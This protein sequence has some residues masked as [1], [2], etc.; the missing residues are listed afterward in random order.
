LGAPR[1]TYLSATLTCRTSNSIRLAMSRSWFYVAYARL[2]ALGPR[3]KIQAELVAECNNV[4]WPAGDGFYA[5]VS[6]EDDSVEAVEMCYY[7]KIAPRGHADRAFAGTYDTTP[8]FYMA[9][10]LI[11][12]VGEPRE[13]KV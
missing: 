7:S 4:E 11:R 1:H 12:S 8:G 2:D 3:S 6:Y 13:E 5:Y 9:A 10:A